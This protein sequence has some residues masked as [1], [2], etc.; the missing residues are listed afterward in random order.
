MVS[1]SIKSDYTFGRSTIVGLQDRASFFR[2]ADEFFKMAKI[3]S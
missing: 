1:F 3:F 2:K